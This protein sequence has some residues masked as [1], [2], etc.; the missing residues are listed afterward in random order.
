VE[1]T[2]ADRERAARLLGLWNRQEAI[3]RALA[4]ERAR[5]LAPVLELAEEWEQS[6]PSGLSALA[7]AGRAIRTATRAAS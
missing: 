5:A 6:S 3:A 4:D 7:G 1:P 2:G